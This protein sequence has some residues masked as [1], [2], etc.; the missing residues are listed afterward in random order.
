MSSWKPFAPADVGV[1]EDRYSE[2]RINDLYAVA[3]MA[4]DDVEW[5][6]VVV[7]YATILDWSRADLARRIDARVRP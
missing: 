3:A 2:Q 4:S 6:T 7:T 5:Q 1:G